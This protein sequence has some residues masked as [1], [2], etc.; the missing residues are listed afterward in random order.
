MVPVPDVTSLVELNELVAKGDER[1]DHRHIESRRLDADHGKSPLSII[2][3]PQVRP[4]V[5]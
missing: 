3:I 4:G 2:E 5:G 1:D